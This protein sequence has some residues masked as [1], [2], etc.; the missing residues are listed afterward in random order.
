MPDTSTTI[1]FAGLAVAVVVAKLVFWPGSSYGNSRGSGGT[2]SSGGSR[3]RPPREVTEDMIS[4]VSVL[5]PHA[6]RETIRKDLMKTHN[7]E[8]TTDNLLPKKGDSL[9]DK[10]ARGNPS[11]ALATSENWIDDRAQREERLRLQRQQMVLK[12][13][14]RTQEMGK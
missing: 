3:S 4:V 11:L 8:R 14:Q 7:V 2:R 13:R 10:Y 5:V 1:F 6:D 12:A 9:L